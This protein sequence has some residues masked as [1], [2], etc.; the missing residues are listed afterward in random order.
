MHLESGDRIDTE[1]ISR[2]NPNGESP[3]DALREET[4]GTDDPMSTAASCSASAGTGVASA[5]AAR[6]A[7]AGLVIS[8]LS[9]LA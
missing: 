6:R 7:G 9:K 4:E 1:R 5:K 8:I 3:Y 2:V